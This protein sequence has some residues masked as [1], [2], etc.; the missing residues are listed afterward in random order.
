MD[1]SLDNV[2]KEAG[3]AVPAG[4]SAPRVL[5]QTC[6]GM[7]GQANCAKI[8]QAL[9]G[10]TVAQLKPDANGIANTPDLTVGKTYYLF[11]SAVS[12][13]KKVPWHLPL[14]AQ[15]GWTKVVLSTANQVP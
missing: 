1:V 13:A 7:A 15:A 8:V 2:L 3:V 12:Q 9:G 4:T 14:K 5:E 10:H 11:G 6:N